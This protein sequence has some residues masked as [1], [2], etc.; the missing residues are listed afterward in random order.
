M[1]TFVGLFSNASDPLFNG[2]KAFETTYSENVGT[3]VFSGRGH[4]GFT[5]VYIITQNKNWNKI[6]SSKKYLSPLKNAGSGS[7]YWG[8]GVV[9]RNDKIYL[10]GGYSD[11]YLNTIQ[12]I[13]FTTAKTLKDAQ[14]RP[15][16]FMKKLRNAVNNPAVIYSEEKL[17]IVGRTGASTMVGNSGRNWH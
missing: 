3:L 6:E 1:M 17:L 16:I 5:H 14:T 12:C 15:W 9:A 11:G 13:D 10:V 4:G 8:F 2:E 7:D